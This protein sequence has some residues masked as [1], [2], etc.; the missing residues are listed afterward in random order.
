MKNVYHAD[1]LYHYGI[2]GMKWGVRRYQNK[3]GTLTSAGRR[4]LG[5][6]KFDDQ[7]NQDTILNKGTVASRV[8]STN[9][10]DE[11][12]L[13]EYGGSI[14][15]GK[16]Y[17][18]D[19]LSKENTYE[20]KYVSI[21]N[22]KN[23]GR[24]KGTEY[25]LNWFTDGGFEPNSAHVAI[26]T[27]KKDAKVAAGK[28][29]V[30]TLLEEVGSETVTSLIKNNESIKTLTLQYTRDKELF[31]RVNKRIIDEGYDAIEDIN[32]LYSDMPVIFY[33]SSKNLGKPNYVI[34]GKE[35]I[36]RYYKNQL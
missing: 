14:K 30:D 23:S 9:M 24:V 25:Y 15:R 6:D 5:L 32:D 26:Y 29:V 1:E 16:K 22:V 13:P 2:L 7:Y 19:I 35:A 8:V 36:E 34:S 3:N 33:N 18:N 28:K 31:D 21:D 12:T 11:Y 17:I 10:Y 4:K 27:L 20:R